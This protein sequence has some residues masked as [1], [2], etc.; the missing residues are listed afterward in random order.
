LGLNSKWKNVKWGDFAQFRYGKM[1][2][3]KKV[4]G[5]SSLYPVFSGYR[6]TGYYDEFNI[7]EG[8]LVVVA[9]GVGG[10]GDVKLTPSRCYLTNLSIAATTNES[11]ALKKY[12]YY[13][14]ALS[15]LRYLDSGSAQSQVTISDLQNVIIPLPS[16]IEQQSVV[17][18]LSS[19][20]ARIAENK[21]INNHLE[22]MA[23]AIFVDFQ[24]NGIGAIKAV[25]D[26]AE[27]NTDTYSE[28]ENWPFVNYLDTGNITEG[29]ISTIQHITLPDDKLPSRARRKVVANDIVYSTVRPNQRHFGI[30]SFP[31][32][33]LLVS[34]GF[35]VIRS[36]DKAVCNEYLYL[37]L[38]TAAVIEQLQSLAEQSVS[39]YP[40]IK[41]SDIGT[42]DIFVPS[43]ED[44]NDIESRLK[45]LFRAIA[46]NQ[47]ESVHL[48]ALRDTLLPRLISG[49]LSV[50][51]I[52]TAK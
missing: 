20:D 8:E 19:L 2:D 15:N 41:P 33:R 32:E 38:T 39:A 30:I 22:Q 42:L 37:L 21:A 49:E 47:A 46:A 11:I 6:I 48:A 5:D 3:N 4:S 17:D 18:T 43:V 12:L 35:A 34:T 45:P 14:F 44:G 40:S 7:E 52:D 10:T 13:Y 24:D 9:R 16:V 25:K 23:Q 29:D 26:I 31:T 1:P 27:I 36:A 51:D 28:K 50:S